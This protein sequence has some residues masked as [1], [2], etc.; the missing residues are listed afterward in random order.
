MQ[1]VEEERVE[2]KNEVQGN[3]LATCLWLLRDIAVF[4]RV[5]ILARLNA[6]WELIRGFIIPH[7]LGPDFKEGRLQTGIRLMGIIFP[8]VADH[9]PQDYVNATRLASEDLF[10]H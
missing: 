5:F 3:T 10:L 2:K 8:R 7:T 1:I 6:V 4:M 9:G